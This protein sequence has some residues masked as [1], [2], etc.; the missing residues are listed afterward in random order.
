[1]MRGPA[2]DGEGAADAPMHHGPGELHRRFHHHLMNALADLPPEEAE[3]IE[4]IVGRAIE[5][6]KAENPEHLF[7]ISCH[8]TGLSRRHAWL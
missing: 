8:E 7:R 2:P 4:H 6:M 1:M 5:A 3:H